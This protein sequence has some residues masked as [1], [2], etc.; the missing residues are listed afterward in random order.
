MKR[1]SH[2][3]TLIELLI[4]VAII[5]I[6]AATAL[7]WLLRARMSANEASAIGSLRSVVSS[8]M[9]YASSA[10]RGGYAPDLPRLAVAC[11][12]TTVPFMSSDLTMGTSV[13]KSG[14]N[15]TMTSTG[16]ASN[17]CNGSPSAVDFYV[18]AEA[19]N[20]GLSATRAFG[21]TSAAVIWENV[22]AAGAT[23]PTPGQMGAAPTATVRPIQ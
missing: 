17:D 19:A 22:G 12:G 2:G 5:G 18:S 10:A 9:N 4:V 16:S 7:P 14:F 13:V 23:P 3:F 6:L 8:Q 11:P 1:T 15:M 21:A 20:P